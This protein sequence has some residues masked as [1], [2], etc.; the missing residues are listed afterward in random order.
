MNTTL[1]PS[2]RRRGAMAKASVVAPLIALGALLPAPAAQAAVGS[3]TCTGSSHAA[4]NPGLTLTPQTITVTETDTV[5]NCTST[6]S[7]LTS[8]ITA[9]PYSYPVA[10]AGCNYAMVI[11]V[12][13]GSLTVHWNN[14]QT[15]TLTGLVNELTA[16][17]GIV[18]NIAVGTVTAGEFTGAAATITYAYPLVNTL[19]CLAPGGLTSQDGTILVQIIGV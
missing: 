11:P 19:Q 9:G 10:N 16:T 18:Q 2:P 1:N 14:G 17:G 4:Y 15:S 6:D 3:V 12:G 8:V 5:P 7:T 13:G